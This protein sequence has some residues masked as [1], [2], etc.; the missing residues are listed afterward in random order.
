MDGIEIRHLPPDDLRLMGAID[1][2]ERVTYAYRIEDGEVRR[3]EVDWDIPDWFPGEGPHHVDTHIADMVP[4]LDAGGILLGAFEGDRV[5]GLAIVVPSFQEQMAWLAFLHVSRPYRRRGVGAML[6]NEA[7]GLARA[8][9]ATTMYV[10]AIPSGP[11][12]DFYV[13]QGCR[14]T[15]EPHPALLAKEPDDL[16]LVCPL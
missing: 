15:D 5:A 6:W 4:A 9:D 12:V 8:A 16:H 11:A 13:R 14:P 2:G 3:Q 1:R 7:S 10:S